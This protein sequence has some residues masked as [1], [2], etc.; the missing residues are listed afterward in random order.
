M[1][2]RIKDLE[3]IKRPREKLALLGI[4]N[5]DNSELL[6]LI[7]GSGTRKHNA[8]ALSKNI[9]KKFP[10]KKLQNLVLDDLSN[11][12]GIGNALASKILASIEIGKR[13]SQDSAIHRISSPEDVIREV[14]EIRSK[15]QEYLIALYLNA[16]HE[17]VEKQVI[18][19]GSLNQN[20]IE[21]RDIFAH[22]LTTPCRFVILTHNHPSG[23][24]SPSE[25]DLKFTSR[26]IKAS[27]IL[28]IQI[29]DHIII[30]KRDYYSFKENRKLF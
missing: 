18:S 9:L 3:K 13:L 21:P 7:I 29:L 20:I 2:T 1:A 12:D 15:S 30:S 10:K 19:I 6:A 27:E 8:L 14:S 25:D 23:D 11:I 24:V 16:R 17:L 4:E 28:G 26:L 22:A 5:L